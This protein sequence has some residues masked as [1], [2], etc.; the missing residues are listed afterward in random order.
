MCWGPLGGRREVEAGRLLAEHYEHWRRLGKVARLEA[1]PRSV[2]DDD[3]LVT[4]ATAAATTQEMEMLRQRMERG[5]MK[6]QQRKY[7]DEGSDGDGD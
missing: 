3:D 6:G 7:G 2:R 5:A 4:E 1:P